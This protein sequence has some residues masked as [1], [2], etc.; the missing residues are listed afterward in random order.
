[1]SDS[2]ARRVG[3]ISTAV[4]P[5]QSGLKQKKKDQYSMEEGNT[6][7]LTVVDFFAFG[8]QVCTPPGHFFGTPLDYFRCLHDF[9]H[10]ILS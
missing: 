8:A 4:N 10:P 2:V 3:E 5:S 9:F 6:A 1:M 7:L